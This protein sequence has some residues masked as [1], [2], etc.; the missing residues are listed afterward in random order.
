MAFLLLK[1]MTLAPRMM[2][3]ISL[4]VSSFFSNSMAPMTAL[5]V[6]SKGIIDPTVIFRSDEVLINEQIL[7]CS[8]PVQEAGFLDP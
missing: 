7:Q 4:A 3:F 2:S 8:P 6:A 5:T 1:G